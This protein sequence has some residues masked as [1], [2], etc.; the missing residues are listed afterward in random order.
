MELTNLLPC[1]S[2]SSTASSKKDSA[3][4]SKMPHTIAKRN[5][6][7]QERQRLLQPITPLNQVRARNAKRSIQQTN[8]VKM[9]NSP[10][11]ADDDDLVLQPEEQNIL[12][13]FREQLLLCKE[14]DEKFE[15]CTEW[16]DNVLKK[17]T[18]LQFLAA[19]I[20]EVMI[21][22]CSKFKS[23][24]WKKIDA[25]WE[26]F[27][28]VA[29]Q[30]V[31]QIDKCLPP[32]RAVASIW[33]KEIVQHYDWAKEGEFY[34]KSLRSTAG[35]ITDLDEFLTKVGQLQKRRLQLPRRRKL[36]RSINPI[37]LVDLENARE[38]KTKEPYVKI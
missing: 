38:W 8:I 24:S 4:R 32:L 35:E 10:A 23:R 17:Y 22:E 13:Q 29:Q 7:T 14:D 31:R 9:M 1:S 30:G 5:A 6:G 18:A 19:K 33:G 21:S 12:K 36:K 20:E 15:A 28:G 16:R 25:N 34:C 37:D 27:I 11:N 26:R 3:I 2:N